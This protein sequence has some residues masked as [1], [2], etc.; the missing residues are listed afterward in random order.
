MIAAATAMWARVSSAFGAGVSMAVTWVSGLPGKALSALGNVG[1]ILVAS[2]QALI[3]GF[4]NGILGMI[5]KVTSAVGHVVSAARRFFPFSPA[6]EGPFSGKGWVLYSGRSIGSAF[7]QG[8]E[9]TTPDAVRASAG[10]MGATAD[11]LQGYRA[12]VGVA[13][14][15]PWSSS[16]GVNSSV[17]IGQ[18]V[19]ADPAAPL[20]EA[21]TMQLRAQI[22]AGVA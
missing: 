21:R 13:A 5:G 12:G 16:G 8:I 20:R 15:A 22:K 18:I 10:L 14:G 7:A 6:K 11:N 2:G 9:D 4:I 3:Q 19:A 17:N 1:S